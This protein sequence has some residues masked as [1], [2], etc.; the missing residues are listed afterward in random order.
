M[1][2]MEILLQI[3]NSTGDECR[4]LSKEYFDMIEREDREERVKN[5]I[6]EEIKE[7]DMNDI[8]KES[9]FEEDSLE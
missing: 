6:K 4:Q 8:N 5:A 2:E 1:S 9:N 7:E 3:L